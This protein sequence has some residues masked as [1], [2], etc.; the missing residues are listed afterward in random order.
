MIIDINEVSDTFFLV[1]KITRKYYSL[2]VIDFIN[3]H[4]T[5]KLRSKFAPTASFISFATSIQL[6]LTLV[7][8]SLLP[9]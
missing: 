2:V 1:A 5:T 3:R 9:L 4:F 8:V 7:V 6:F